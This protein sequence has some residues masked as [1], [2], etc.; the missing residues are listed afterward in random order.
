MTGCVPE[1]LDV[2]YSVKRL[3]VKLIDGFLHQVRTD[4][5][6]D[7]ATLYPVSSRRVRAAHGN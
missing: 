7:R 5:R 3:P 6:A 2:D 4:L 1:Q